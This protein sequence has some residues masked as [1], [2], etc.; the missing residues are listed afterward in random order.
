MDDDRELID[1]EVL[2]RLQAG[3]RVT[4]E[5]YADASRARRGLRTIADGMLQE[6]DILALPTAPIV[7]PKVGA[8]SIQVDGKDLEVRSALLSLTNLWNMTGMP[9][10]SVPAGTL[11]GLPVAIQLLV[12]P[13][14]ERTMFAAAEALQA[15]HATAQSR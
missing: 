14:N 6:F 5:L 7:A 13:G 9:A 2:A 4:S 12:A 1:A 11:E 3:G 10:I 15:A 8:R